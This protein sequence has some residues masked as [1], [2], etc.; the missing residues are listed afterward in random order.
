MKAVLKSGV[1]D[2]YLPRHLKK[3]NLTWE[4]LL[5]KENLGKR[6]PNLWTIK[7]C[8]IEEYKDRWG[9]INSRL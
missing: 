8:D 2:N 3:N 4:Q 9:T 6:K 1:I 7:L 5:K